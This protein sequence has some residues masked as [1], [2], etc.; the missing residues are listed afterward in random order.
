[1]L[2][3][4]VDHVIG[5]DPDRDRF[6][7]SIVVAANAGEVATTD[8]ATTAAGYAAAIEWADAHGT[9][10]AS[11]V[12]A[13]EGTA[14]YGAGLTQSLASET[15]WVIEFDRPATRAA[16]D[17]AKTDR[18][19]AVRAA[20]EVLG[21]N[22]WATPR[23][24]GEREG[25]R[26]LM[27]ARTS[28]QRARTAAINELRALVLTAP[29]GLRD[30]LRGLSRSKLIST[31]ARLRPA[32]GTD[33]ELVAT[34]TAMR[35]LARRIETLTTEAD[36]LEAAMAPLI[37][38]MGPQLLDEYGI[39]TLIAAQILISWSHPGR[40]RNEAAF[41]RLG[42][43]APIETTSGQTQNRHRL[44]RGGDRQLNRALHQIILVRSA[45]HPD[46]KT[47]IE[48]R[49]AEGKTRREARRCLKRYLA[50]HLYRILENPPH[51][52]P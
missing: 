10:P 45:H 33:A 20:R 41:A 48:R 6:T 14:S 50:R 47:Y 51:Q 38:T 52:T 28:A 29:V 22:K 19:D 17:G 39:G 43:A 25:L 7:A 3:D 9:D 27:V 24:R 11:R 15:E 4:L 44:N 26:A 16:R 2:A 30:Q 40:C 21:R 12:W 18:L 23:C 35:A 1:M 49:V 8:F 13:I 31:C 34:K 46:T 36:E 37:E 32:T 5:V 42:A